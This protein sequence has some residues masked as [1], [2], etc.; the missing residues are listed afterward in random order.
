MTDIDTLIKQHQCPTAQ[1]HAQLVEAMTMTQHQIREYLAQDKVNNE[2]VMAMQTTS[3]DELLAQLQVLTQ[4][5][6]A[7]EYIDEGELQLLSQRMPSSLQ[8]TWH[9]FELAIEEFDFDLAQG[10]LHRLM[11]Q[12]NAA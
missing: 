3:K 6:A 12:L 8:A 4:R 7:S 5:V 11:T 2:G 10:V 1:Q 9:S